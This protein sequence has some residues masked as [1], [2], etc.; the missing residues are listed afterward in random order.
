MFIAGFDQT[1]EAYHKGE[2]SYLFSFMVFGNAGKLIKALV[3]R[4][5][6]LRCF[7]LGRAAVFIMEA[8]AAQAMWLRVFWSINERHGA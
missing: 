5:V 1:F 6:S 2:Q 4:A 7:A 3:N 8:R